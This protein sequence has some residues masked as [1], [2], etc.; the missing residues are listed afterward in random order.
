MEKKEKKIWE[1]DH[2]IIFDTSSLLDF[3]FFPK[4][5][6]EKI[7]ETVFTELKDRLWIPHHVYFEFQKNRKSVIRKPIDKSYSPLKEIISNVE[8][9][10]K[11]IENK[12]KDFYQRT[13]ESDRLPHIEETITKGYSEIVEEIKSK[14]DVFN[15]NLFDQIE[16]SIN[17][18]NQ[19]VENDDHFEKVNEYFDI[20]RKYEYSELLEI[21]KEGEFRYRNTIPPGY[22]D[23]SDKEGIQ[24]F[25]DLILW[26]Q[27]LEHI[28]DCHVIFI[29]DDTKS[30]WLTNTKDGHYF[31]RF[32]LELELK[33]AG[34]KE[35]WIYNQTDF[36]RAI[37]DFLENK[38]EEDDI[39]S[40]ELIIE[41]QRREL[42]ESPFLI[43]RCTNCGL[44]SK[45]Y[46]DN[47]HIEY[48][49]VGSYEMS[50]GTEIEY[51]AIL[52]LSCEYCTNDLEIIYRAWEYPLGAL[53]NTDY[54]SSGCEVIETHFP[55]PPLSI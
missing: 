1:E 24:K 20:G 55:D 6:R 23:F 9:A 13:K 11:N 2:I 12:Y 41:E 31:P 14:T 33:S 4:K 38:V 17:E 21:A 36:L 44:A 34:G 28:N 52:N 10:I 29:T 37:N 35:L 42:D 19:T 26:K 18:I 30:D 5:T 49:G 15:K 43:C 50:M 45:H 48:E 25:G 3:Y 53:N 32:E 51:E 54:E 39:S 40:I 46:K 27:I 16:K 47:I 8:K 7:Y 22:K